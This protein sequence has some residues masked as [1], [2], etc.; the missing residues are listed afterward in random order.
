M[1]ILIVEDNLIQ[2]KVLEFNLKKSGY[3]VE[4]VAGGKEALAVLENQTDV[5]LVI[6]DIVMPGIN[7]LELLRLMKAHPRLNSI[8]VI[9]CTSLSDS[10]A[11]KK[12]AR[13]GCRFYIVKPMQ[14]GVMLNMVRQAL[15]GGMRCW[16]TSKKPGKTWKWT[17]PLFA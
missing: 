17:R 3:Q 10:E 13:L 14:V 5:G 9:L 6:T 8:P 11:I 2:R 12:A 1:K 16:A 15:E 4:V 7:G